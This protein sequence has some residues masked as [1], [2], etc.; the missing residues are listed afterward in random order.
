MNKAPRY[1]QQREIIE[2]IVCGQKGHLSVE[3]IFEQAKGKQPRISLG[4]VYRNLRQLEDLK[5]ISQAQGLDQ[6]S[7]YEAYAEPHHHFVCE[8]CGSIEDIDAPTVQTC[9]GC[10]SKKTPLQ[11]RAVVTTLYGRCGRCQA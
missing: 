5:R 1:S 4:T 8:D 9:T 2:S 3:Q 7:F 6:V 11:I 10:I